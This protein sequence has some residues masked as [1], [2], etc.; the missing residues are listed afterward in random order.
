MVC[1]TYLCDI[2][3]DDTCDLATLIYF[4]FSIALTVS[5]HRLGML[6]WV[7]QV[8]RLVL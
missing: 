6:S 5:A 4:N 7:G 8:H 2:D 3:D 1:K